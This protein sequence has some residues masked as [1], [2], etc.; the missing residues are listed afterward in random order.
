[1]PGHSALVT[2]AC[3]AVVQ[4][5]QQLGRRYY[6]RKFIAQGRDMHVMARLDN[7]SLAIRQVET[8]ARILDQDHAISQIGTNPHACGQIG[9]HTSELQSL[10]RTSYA[11]FCLKKQK[12]L[13]TRQL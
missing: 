3:Y 11:V 13:N 9:R 7:A 8:V 6:R 2:S 4:R 1:M 5:L 10:M 12:Q